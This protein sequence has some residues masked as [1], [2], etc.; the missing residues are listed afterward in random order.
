MNESLFCEDFFFFIGSMPFILLHAFHP[1]MSVMTSISS[2]LCSARLAVAGD[3]KD[4]GGFPPYK[5]ELRIDQALSH[6]QSNA[7][8]QHEE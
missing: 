2:E 6:Q 1:L 8:R 7:R 4:H 5:E 3:P